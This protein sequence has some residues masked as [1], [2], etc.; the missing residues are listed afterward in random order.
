MK[1]IYLL[2]GLVLSS[3]L[4]SAQVSWQSVTQLQSSSG[5]VSA[6]SVATDGY[7]SVVTG[8]FTGTIRFG[9]FT[10]VSRGTSDLFVVRYDPS[11]RALWA[12]QFGQSPNNV[13]GYSQAS[14]SGNDIALDAAGNAYLVGSFTGSITY[15]GGALQSY[16]SGFQAGL[17]VKLN[18]RGQVQWAQRFG[19]QQF[20]CYGYAIATDATG[21]SYITGQSDYG[22]IEFG[23]KVYGPNSRRVLYVAAYRT[24]GEVAWATVSGNFSSYGA[25]GS[26]VALDGRGNCYVGGFFNND[27]TLAGAALTTVGADS[28]LARF[29]AAS[30]ALQWLKQGGGTGSPAANN[31]VRIASLSTDRQGNVYVAGEFSG[32]TSLGGQP[33]LGNDAWQ[34]D[35][36]VARYAS[37]GAVQWAKSTGTTA[38]EYSTQ[39][40]TNADGF[41]TLVGRRLNASFESKLLLHSFQPTG[42]LHYSDVIGTS[43]SCRSYGI[44][45]DANGL[46]YITGT[47]GGTATFGATTL[48]TGTRTDGFVARF[49]LRQPTISTN[50]TFEVFPNPARGR[51]IA[52]LTWGEANMR[53]AGRATLT[54]ALGRQVSTQAVPASPAAHAQAIFDCS[55]LPLGLYILQFTT[56]D[57]A[58]YSQSVEVQ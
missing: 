54:N 32:V 25:S 38:A 27:M 22:N 37:T 30:G 49:N 43:G 7:G 5:E 4:A 11:G 48:Q 8:S 14:A 36:F 1:T 41:S 58:S 57:G 35:I 50:P 34:P 42:S 17:V 18:G 15:P 53:L 52:R 21:T 23:N 9:A 56:S 12:V 20:G 33:L 10:L 16:A 29:A 31:N 40:T 51:I 26:D 47:L 39:L 55:S 46:L 24:G 6:R 45:Q 3:F 28:Y 19:I 13:P 2:L 44:T